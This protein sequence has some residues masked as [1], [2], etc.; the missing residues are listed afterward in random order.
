MPDLRE[1]PSI[2]PPGFKSGR[3]VKLFDVIVDNNGVKLRKWIPYPGGRTGHTLDE[4]W[5]VT[6][7]PTV[8]AEEIARIILEEAPNTPAR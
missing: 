7:P 5:S 1:L 2:L 4:D 8:A 6:L 3:G